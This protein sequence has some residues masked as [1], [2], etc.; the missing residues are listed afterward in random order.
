MKYISIIFI[1]FITGCTNQNSIDENN[2][3]TNIKVYFSKTNGALYK[4]GVDNLIIKDINNSQKTI[5]MAMYDLTNKNITQALIDA[6]N[7]GIEIKI[8]TD[9]DKINDTRYK[10]QELISRGITVRDDEDSS[11]LMHNKLLVIDDEILWSGSCNY[12]VYAFYRNNENLV[13]IK[14]SKIA[15]RGTNQIL[16]LFNHSNTILEIY[17]SKKVDIYFSPEHNFEDKLVDMIENA[18]HSILF[19]AFVMTNAKISNALI[20]AKNRGVD[21]KGILDEEQNNY[22]AYSKYQTL[23]DNNISVILDKNS[24]KLHNKVIIIDENTTI[25]GSYNFT[26][27]AND[28][29]AENSVI[30]YDKNIA[31]KYIE[32][33]NK[34]Y[35]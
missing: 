7:R 11:A 35:Q 1:V 24:Y 16:R 5:D 4:D 28:Y 26:N 27:K 8:I 32:E 15:K 2:S 20:D 22:Q 25:T 18:D 34:E 13:R 12:T 3:S 19:L 23:K 10:Y 33:F 30:I 17:K 9:D 6:H 21:I 29:N 14:D 31:N